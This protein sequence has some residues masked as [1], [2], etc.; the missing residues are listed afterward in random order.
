MRSKGSCVK[1]CVC[2]EAEASEAEEGDWMHEHC[3]STPHRCNQIHWR[4]IVDGCN[5]CHSAQE[6][7]VGDQYWQSYKQL[8]CKS[9]HRLYWRGFSSLR[10]SK[11]LK[12]SSRRSELVVALYAPAASC[13]A[14]RRATGETR[15]LYMLYVLRIMPM[16]SA[17]FQKSA[18]I[19]VCITGL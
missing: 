1:L 5:P 17:R 13:T 19:C 14:Q 7:G 11:V 15:E 9:R 12:A 10:S 18:D 16:T 6:I 4:R 2:L 8:A 3:K